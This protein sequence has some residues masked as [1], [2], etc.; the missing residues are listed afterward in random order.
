MKPVI[1]IQTEKETL[2]LRQNPKT[3]A[4]IRNKTKSFIFEI[5]LELQFKTMENSV[6]L[7]VKL[8]REKYHCRR[9][10]KKAGR[11][12]ILFK[13]FSHCMSFFAMPQL[14]VALLAVKLFGD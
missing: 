13:N 8:K 6:C 4:Q 10:F 7:S 5:V 9:D 11:C 14:R 1:L 12:I 2:K 3:K